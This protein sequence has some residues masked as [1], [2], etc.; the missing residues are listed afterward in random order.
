MALLTRS[1][2]VEQT[3]G[4]K[5]ERILV[6]EWGGEVIVREMTAQEVTKIGVA[7]MDSQEGQLSKSNVS[8]EQIADTMP[9]IVAWTVVNEDLLPLLTL[10]DV[11]RMTSDYMEVIQ[12]LGLKALE[13]SDLT[14]DDE[15]ES[16]PN[17]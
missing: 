13:L 1:K 5:T 9:Q 15:G 10:E 7:A 17:A 8:L 4:Y 2:I 14:E 12:M 3:Q 16:D 11:Q 6:P